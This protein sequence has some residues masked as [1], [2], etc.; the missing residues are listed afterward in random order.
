MEKKRIYTP[1]LVLMIVGLVFSLISPLVAYVC[2]II[3]I[4]MAVKNRAAHSF[5]LVIGLDVLA[6]ILAVINHVYTA[7]LIMKAQG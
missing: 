1:A 7:M 2:C 3:S 6:L 5:K 4:V